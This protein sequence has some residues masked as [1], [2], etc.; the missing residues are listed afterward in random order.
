MDSFAT[1]IQK[2]NK[3]KKFIGEVANNEWRNI[4]RFL[5][6]SEKHKAFQVIRDPRAILASWYPEIPRC[7]HALQDC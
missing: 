4:G 1:Y 2:K 6:M 5:K 3:G 7:A